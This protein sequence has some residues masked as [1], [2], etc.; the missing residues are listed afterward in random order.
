M[1]EKSARSWDI[2]DCFRSNYGKEYSLCGFNTWPGPVVA[3]IYTTPTDINE[4]VEACDTTLKSS[5]DVHAPLRWV[6]RPTCQSEPCYIRRR[7]P[8]RQATDPVFG[9]ER[10]NWHIQCVF[11]AAGP[12]VWNSLPPLLRLTGSYQGRRHGFE[13]GG[14]KF[15]ERTEQKIVLTPHFLASGGTK[16][17]LNG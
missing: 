8:C 14:D 9:L 13:S 7:M 4:F 2:T 11:S 3:R 5:I 16:Y 15:C 10:S 1:Q 17:C 6:R 12:L